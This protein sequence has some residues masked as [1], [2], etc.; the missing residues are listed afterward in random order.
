VEVRTVVFDFGNV[1]GHFSRHKAAEQLAAFGPPALSGESVLAYLFETDL[2]YRFECGLVSPGEVIGRLR[3]EFG[4]RGSDED[5]ALA[6]ADMFTPNEEVCRLV[7]ELR[8]RLGLALLSN[9]NA[10][11]YPHFCRQFAETLA[12]FDLLVASYEVGF[13]KPDPRIFRHVEGRLGCR[14]GECL[15]IDDLPENVEAARACG[16]HGLIYRPGDDLRQRLLQAGVPL[17]A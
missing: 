7:R 13:R 11:H 3:Q 9:T 15:F 2:E 14:P 8:G 10:V 17:A 16:W 12:C 1:L 5:L 4:L 6:Y